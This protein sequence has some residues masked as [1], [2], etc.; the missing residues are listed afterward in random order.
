M[1]EDVPV[2]PA[3]A[4]A[5]NLPPM[6]A[7]ITATDAV[8]DATAKPVA[9]EAGATMATAGGIRRGLPRVA[10]GQ[11]WP[12]GEAPGEAPGEVPPTSNA[13]AD[14]A[15]AST[16]AAPAAVT[17]PLVMPPAATPLAVTPTTGGAFAPTVPPPA[18]PAQATLAA[19]TPERAAPAP[20]AQQPAPA[21]PAATAAASALKLT[22]RQRVGVAAVGVFALFGFATAIVL[23]AR[24]VVGFEPVSAFVER[25]PGEYELPSSAP[26]GL[27]AWLGWQHFFNVFFLVLIVRTGLQVRQQQRPAAFWAPKRNPQQKISLMLWFHQTLDVLWL[28]NGVIFVVLLFVTGQ[29]MRIVPTSWEVFPNAL[30]AAL[31]YLTLNWP[32]ENGWINYNSLQQLAYFSIVFIGAPLAIASGVRLSGF[33]PAQNAKLNKAYPVEIARAVHFPVMLFFVGFTIIHV[34]LVLTTGAL[35]NLNH[36]YGARDEVSW[37]GAIMLLISL[38]VIAGAFIA[39]RPMVLAPLARTMGNVSAR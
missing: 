25:Y 22:T 18:P 34:T 9:A 11:P 4:V 27:P 29:W 39:A 24:W 37:F 16:E 5:E 31:Q 3:A 32:V 2:L 8:I 6:I 28:T 17:P 10:G 12:I 1:L 38:A 23:L 26:V 36:I 20:V 14:S 21:A 15:A 19:V 35:R 33:W 30:S 7:P 13:I